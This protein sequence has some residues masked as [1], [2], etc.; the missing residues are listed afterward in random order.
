MYILLQRKN[1]VKTV[2]DENNKKPTKKQKNPR[3]PYFK[4]K[5]M[6]QKPGEEY[7]SIA[8]ISIPKVLSGDE[9]RIYRHIYEDFQEKGIDVEH[10]LRG[11]ELLA[12][13]FW[14]ERQLEQVLL[15]NGGM[16]YESNGLIKE[17]PAAKLQLGVHRQI[18]DALKEY[19]QT[20]A[21]MKRMNLNFS[22]PEKSDFEGM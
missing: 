3:E 13:L 15:E 14:K 11:I 7:H 8:G 9:A 16:V 6:M 21:S 10:F 17:H 19:G 5:D 18:L 2:K 1:G 22:K 20:P 12:R 4:K